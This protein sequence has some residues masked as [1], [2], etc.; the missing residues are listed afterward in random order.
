MRNESLKHTIFI[1][2]T[3]L[4]KAIGT[5]LFFGLWLGFHFT[6]LMLGI[7]LTKVLFM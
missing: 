5:A 2:S 6:G 4:W 7:S 3:K 1:S